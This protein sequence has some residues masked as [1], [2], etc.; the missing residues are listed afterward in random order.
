MMCR[1]Q[2]TLLRSGFVRADQYVLSGLAPADR[3]DEWTGIDEFRLTPSQFAFGVGVR[4]MARVC[5]SE[6]RGDSRWAVPCRLSRDGS[7]A[8]TA[9]PVSI[10]S[11][12]VSASLCRREVSDNRPMALHA[13]TRG[14]CAH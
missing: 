2:S 4:E 14:E 12:L 7:G 9:E 8:D 11:L 13:L 6:C 10:A 5:F 1:S 3:A